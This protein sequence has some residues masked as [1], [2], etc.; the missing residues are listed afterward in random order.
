MLIA[1]GILTP[2]N[3]GFSRVVLSVSASLSNF[4]QS[5]T[6][7]P[8]SLKSFATAVPQLPLP[9]TDIFMLI[10]PFAIKQSTLYSFNIK[11][12]IIRDG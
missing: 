2:F 4:D 8:F 10:I 11:D 6:S 5:V 12:P 3:N 1:S 9:K 7:L